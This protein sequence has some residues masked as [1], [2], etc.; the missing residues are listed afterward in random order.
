M[1][2]KPSAASISAGA[3]LIAAAGVLTPWRVAF[4]QR[5]E[6]EVASVKHSAFNGRFEPLRRSGTLVTAHNTQVG[7]FIWYAYNIQGAYQV[8][9]I[10]NWADDVRWFDLDARTPANATEEQVRLMMQSLLE[11]RFKM[12][13]HRETK[14]LPAYALMLG[15]G[16]LK[17]AEASSGDEPLIVT[18]ESRKLP[19]APGTCSNSLWV[20]GAHLVCHAVTIQR[21]ATQVGSALGS[22]VVDRTG[23][24]GKYDM[25][26][27]YWPDDRPPQTGEI[28]SPTI[29][30]ALGDL[31]LRL[32]K[33]T[34]PVEVLVIDRIEQPTEN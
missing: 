29:S 11:N 20:A 28:L 26:L 31:G 7:S 30:Q 25:D 27:L 23:L 17:L 33:S 5:P 9:G 24:T 18:I 6:F 1:I 32:E 21:I 2:L 15:K 22:P 8:E 12:K 16:K 14:Q 3:L 34:G 13:S 10:P 19:Q 4:A